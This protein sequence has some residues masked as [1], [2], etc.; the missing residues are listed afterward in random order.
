MYSPKI[1][2]KWARQCPWQK[3]LCLG[4]TPSQFVFP[5]SETFKVYNAFWAMPKLLQV[6]NILFLFVKFQAKDVWATTLE[7]TV[8]LATKDN[9]SS[10]SWSRHTWR[11]VLRHLQLLTGVALSYKRPQLRSLFCFFKQFLKRI[12][13]ADFNGIWTPIA[14]IEG[15]YAD[16]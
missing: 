2:W 5:V 14:G 8:C 13:T 15:Q 3:I 4:R 11:R 6:K 10:D 7:Q 9:W 16:H 12:K 1:A